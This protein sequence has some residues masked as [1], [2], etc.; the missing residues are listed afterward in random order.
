MAI[1]F[2]P[3]IETYFGNRY[4][5]MALSKMDYDTADNLAKQLLVQE[6][7]TVPVEPVYEA[8]P[9]AP[10]AE[11]KTYY[12]IKFKWEYNS[13]MTYL[14][15]DNP[16]DVKR[17][18]DAFNAA[19]GKIGYKD[20]GN[21]AINERVG[22]FTGVESE[23]FVVPL[24]TPEQKKLQEQI[25]SVKDRNTRL[26]EDYEKSCVELDK[27]RHWIV[28]QR[29]A[30]TNVLDSLNTLARTFLSTNAI[31][32]DAEKTF[33]LLKKNHEYDVTSVVDQMHHQAMPEGEKDT[34]D[35]DLLAFIQEYAA[36][37]AQR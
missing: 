23:S 17:I 14:A 26:R 15:F 6:G 3:M 13:D 29:D 25:N 16:E 10:Q 11:K 35:A 9:E 1:T 20:Y 5:F 7:Q 8:V 2:K 31:V 30:A 36:T 22:A 28:E 37:L 18:I 34:T 27:Q 24:F 12:G 32:G 19:T 33:A 4:D 21:T